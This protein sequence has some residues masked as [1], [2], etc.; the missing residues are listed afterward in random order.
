M[1]NISPALPPSMQITDKRLE[2][3]KWKRQ[4]FQDST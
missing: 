4:R 3:M 2:N 1:F